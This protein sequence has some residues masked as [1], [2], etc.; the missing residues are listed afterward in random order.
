MCCSLLH[1]IHRFTS[2]SKDQAFQSTKKFK[3]IL[4]NIITNTLVPK[5]L[6][7]NIFVFLKCSIVS[8]CV[9]MHRC[10]VVTS[11]IPNC[12]GC[13]YANI[14]PVYPRGSSR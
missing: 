2:Y 14:F 11:S 6:S 4:I 12:M 13:V 3:Y 5:C 9:V 8:N 1:I 10:F 7:N